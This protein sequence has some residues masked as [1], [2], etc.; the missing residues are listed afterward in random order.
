MI[1]IFVN[2]RT[3]PCGSHVAI[4]LVLSNKTGFPV[5]SHDDVINWRHFPRYWPF[6]R[7]I[8]RSSCWISCTRPV[9][10]SFDVFFDPRLNKQLSK[11]SHGWGFET[12][13]HPLWHQCNGLNVLPRYTEAWATCLV[14]Y[15][16]SR[17]IYSKYLFCIVFFLSI[18]FCDLFTDI[19]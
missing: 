4:F 15:S 18:T 5:V 3:H 14:K 8:H 9:T 16:I 11:Q 7:G 6:V 2:T 13:L 12:P 19:I 10:R 1:Y 17:K